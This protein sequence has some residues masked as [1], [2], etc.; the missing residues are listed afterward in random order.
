MEL[1]SFI[2]GHTTEVTKQH[3]EWWNVNDD[4]KSKLVRPDV[5]TFKEEL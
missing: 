5:K 4:E 2:D 3:D 1:Q